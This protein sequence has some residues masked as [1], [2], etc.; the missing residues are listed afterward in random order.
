MAPRTKLEITSHT[1]H[2]SGTV[3]YAEGKFEGREFVA[4]WATWC[5]LAATF[6]D[7]WLD[8]TAAQCKSIGKALTEL[9]AVPEV[10]PSPSAPFQNEATSYCR[11]A[12]KAN[13]SDGADM[14][15]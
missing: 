9:G 12:R 8:A 1:H 15:R 14:Q 2:G 4:S 11:P 7:T 6:Y 3:G 5:T 13:A 10:T